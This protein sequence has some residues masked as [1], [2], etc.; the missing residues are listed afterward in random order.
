[1]VLL[2]TLVSTRCVQKT[3]VGFYQGCGLVRKLQR[4]CLQP[5]GFDLAKNNGLSGLVPAGEKLTVDHHFGNNAVYF[6]LAH[7][8]H[9]A[10]LAEREGV[11]LSR[12]GKQVCSQS[13]KLDLGTQ[14]HLDGFGRT[15]T[16]DKAPNLQILTE[17]NTG[18][19]VALHQIV[20]C[21]H[22]IITSL[23]RWSSKH[24]VIIN[25]MVLAEGT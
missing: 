17:L 1:V 13:F 4:H 16:R 5:I 24:L 12:K 10:Q 22:D 25:I 21:P 11:V 15:F 19:P 2:E 14:H 20:G 7:F 18:L 6:V 23:F 3:F 8:K 9:G